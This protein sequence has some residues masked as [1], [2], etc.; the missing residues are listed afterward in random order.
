MDP[1]SL[2]IGGVLSLAGM[3][4]SAIKGGQAMKANDRLLNQQEA[5]NKAWYN[6]NRNYFDSVQGKSALEQVRDSMEAR[7]KTDAGNAVI[8]GATP[9][10]EIAMK[11]SQSKGYADAIRQVAT[12]GSEYAARNEGIYRNTLNNI[13]AQKMGNNMMKAQNAANVAGNM[14][15]MFGS[16]AK[17][18]LFDK[19]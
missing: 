9:E 14:G 8:M 19:N 6:N 17:A 16:A 10:A 18:G 11:D 2:G 3:A 12:Q 4:Y 13:Y 5:E 7:R 1:I 15:N